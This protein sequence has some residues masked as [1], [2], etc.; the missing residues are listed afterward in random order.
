MLFLSHPLTSVCNLDTNIVYRNDKIII[1]EL[2]VFAAFYL[3][4]QL[5]YS[6]IY[7]SVI[8]SEMIIIYIFTK[9]NV[10]DTL[11]LWIINIFTF[12]DGAYEHTLR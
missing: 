2:F 10:M 11:L 7:Y 3:D 4:M 5:V 6:S 12:L 8:G 1:L 9:F